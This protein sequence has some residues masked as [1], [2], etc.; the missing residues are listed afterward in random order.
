MRAQRPAEIPDGR[1]RLQ[2]HHPGAATNEAALKYIGQRGYYPKPAVCKAKTADQNPR[3]I[4]A[5]T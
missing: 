5:T 4:G 1:A 2:C 3:P